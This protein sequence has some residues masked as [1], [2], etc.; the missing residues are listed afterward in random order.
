MA[1]SA[2]DAVVLSKGIDDKKIRIPGA[3]AVKRTVH[4]IAFIDMLYQ[5]ELLKT[6]S[7]HRHILCDASTLRGRNFFIVQE[8]RELR[9]DATAMADR[10][11]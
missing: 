1:M 4:R 11:S 7:G 5:R 2:E 9:E 3:S 10:M 6:H 8:D